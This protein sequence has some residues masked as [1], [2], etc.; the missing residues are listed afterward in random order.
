MILKTC[1]E[2]QVEV[3]YGHSGLSGHPSE[4]RTQGGHW[5]IDG[6]DEGVALLKLKYM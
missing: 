5:W 4:S 3:F 1:R 2:E 6:P